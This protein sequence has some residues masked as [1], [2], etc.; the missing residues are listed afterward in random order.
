MRFIQIRLKIKTG[1]TQKKTTNYL[2]YSYIVLPE[3][4]I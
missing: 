3:S 4:L 1:N 2:L